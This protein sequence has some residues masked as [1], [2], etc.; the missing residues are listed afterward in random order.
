MLTRS[1]EYAVRALSLLALR[2]GRGALHSAEIAAELGLPP[3]FLSKILR[4]LTATD[5]VISQRGRTGGFR[6]N[7]P[8]AEITLLAVVEPF[9]DGL[10]GVECLLGQGACTDTESCPLHSSMTEI[11]RSFRDLLAG[12]T[13]ADVARRAVRTDGL[14]IRPAG[15]PTA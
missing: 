15:G 6:L 7:R 10:D 14:G 11:R 8:S 12:T 3:Q 1:A 2:D 4:R 13:L 9:L 5:L